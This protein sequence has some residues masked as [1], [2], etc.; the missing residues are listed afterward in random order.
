[1]FAG[2]GKNAIKRTC[3]SRHSRLQKRAADLSF[4]LHTTS[5]DIDLVV[6]PLAVPLHYC[7]IA[8]CLI[9]LMR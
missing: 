2:T 5:G 9:T 3:V 4:L 7:V 8:Y 1:L 6:L